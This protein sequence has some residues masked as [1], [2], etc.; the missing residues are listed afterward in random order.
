MSVRD[1]FAL[2]FLCHTSRD[3]LGLITFLLLLFSSL[4]FSSLHF[5]LLLDF[6]DAFSHL[7]RR[8]CPSVGQSIRPSVGR[9]VHHTRV[10]FPRNELNFNK[11]VSGTWKCHL[12]DYSETSTRVDRQN[13]SVVWT[14]SSLFSFLDASS[15]LYMRV[16]PSVCPWVRGSVCPSVSI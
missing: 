14:L 11:I 16:C 2:S 1:L 12:K 9:S 8:V 13:A 5:F 10:E 7:Y 3:R 4:L 6:L 15:H